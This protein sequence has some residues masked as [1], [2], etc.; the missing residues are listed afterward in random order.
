MARLGRA[1]IRRLRERRDVE[2]ALEQSAPGEEERG[3][4]G[5][6]RSRLWL[7]VW[8]ALAAVL[9]FLA[10]LAGSER[11]TLPGSSF[12]ILPRLP[13][14]LA[15]VFAALFVERLVE[16]YG[17]HKIES[18]VTRYNTTRVVRLAAACLVLGVIGA[19]LVSNLYTGLVSLG[20]ISI[21]VG[22][23]VQTPMTSFIGWLYIL[24]R[25]PY[26][27]GDRIEIDDATGDVIEVSYLDT[28]LWEFGGKYLSGDHP[29]GRII[30]FPNSKVLNTPVFNY[31]WPLFP[32]IWNEIKLQIAYQ[33]DLEFVARA[34]Q[35]VAEEELGPKMVERV[36]VYRSL[37]ARTPVDRLTVQEKPVV[38]F[39]VSE[40]TWL[41]AILRY[42]VNPRRAGRVKTELLRKLLAR[43]NRE[44]GRVMFP[45]AD[46]R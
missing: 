13:L 25:A 22:L 36:R 5:G 27:V 17:I 38:I 15:L 11:I 20:V 14:A 44:P 7:A 4:F 37:L 24:V 16:M 30:K 9:G 6:R 18:P 3:G 19:V 31:S 8:G 45:K 34:M 2:K 26:R 43:L 10:Y 12:G 35:E 21:I 33:S 41:E 32:Y 40:N 28:T 23:A 42:L 39:R 29:S 46:N 1:A